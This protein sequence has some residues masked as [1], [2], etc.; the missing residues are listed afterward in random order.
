MNFPLWNQVLGYLIILFY[1]I[2]IYLF[3]FEFLDIFLK[4][5]LALV[6]LLEL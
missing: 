2:K 6:T 1:H 4:N 3:F 5:I